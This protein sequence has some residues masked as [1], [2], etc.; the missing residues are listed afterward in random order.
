MSELKA[1]KLHLP[2][3]SILLL[4]FCL[5]TYTDILRHQ[6]MMDDYG[7][8]FSGINSNPFS[9]F[10]GFFTNTSTRHYAPLNDFFNFSLFHVFQDPRP[11][12]FINLMLFYSNCLLLFYF[13]RLISKDYSAALITSILFCIHPMNA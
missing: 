8:L 9:H 3:P 13:V 10:S 6:F 11:L 5:I 7:F 1:N 12:Y 4:L 2:H